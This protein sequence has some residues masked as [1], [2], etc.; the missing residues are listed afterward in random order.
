[1]GRGREKKEAVEARRTGIWE[2]LHGLKFAALWL[3]F[4]RE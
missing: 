3:G 2:N 4:Q 1:M